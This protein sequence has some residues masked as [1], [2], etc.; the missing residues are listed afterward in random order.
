MLLP[1]VEI[2]VCCRE[3]EIQQSASMNLL[4]PNRKR[5]RKSAKLNDFLLTLEKNQA[6]FTGH[7]IHT[8]RETRPNHP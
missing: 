6:Q 4:H 7:D 1:V 3:S 2:V 5:Q 8:Q